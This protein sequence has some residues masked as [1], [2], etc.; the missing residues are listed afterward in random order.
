[1]TKHCKCK[2]I[3]DDDERNSSVAIILN[4]LN[5]FFIDGKLGKRNGRLV[6]SWIVNDF[7]YAILSCW[8]FFIAGVTWDFARS[9]RKIHRFDSLKMGIKRQVTF[10]WNFL[11][12]P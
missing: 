12:P 7:I 11:V 1:M 5:L 8:Y 6:L 3:H 2:T 9:L 4:L 10:L